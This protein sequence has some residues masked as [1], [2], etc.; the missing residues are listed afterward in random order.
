MSGIE[1]PGTPPDL[2][3][4]YADVYREAY[5][6]ALEEDAAAQVPGQQED[7]ALASSGA[8]QAGDRSFLRPWVIGVAVALLLLLVAYVAGNML[9]DNEPASTGSGSRPTAVSSK[10]SGHR[11]THTAAP[12]WEGDVLPVAIEDAAA[13][14]TAPPGVDSSNS[15]VSYA[16]ENAFDDDPS[17]AW[18]CNGK[19]HGESLTFT[20]PAG[21]D[22]AEVGLVPGYAKTDSASGTDRY[23]ENNRIT[24]VRWTLSPGVVIEQDLDPSPDNRT[25]QSIRVPR[26]ATDEVTLE[27]LSVERGTRNTT[28]ISSVLIAAAY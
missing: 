14:C 8:T 6:R 13:T 11:P 7:V 20:L 9:A 23:A 5:L 21:V 28:A 22:V 10:S 19:A 12:A 24:R 26:T 15:P 16:A 17:T 27:I 3:Q 1:D 18:R 4:E 25:I 2:P